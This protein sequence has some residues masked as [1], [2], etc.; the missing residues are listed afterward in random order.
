MDRRHLYRSIEQ[1]GTGD[2]DRK[3]N[4]ADLRDREAG[5]RMAWSNDAGD[6]VSNSSNGINSCCRQLRVGKRARARHRR[7]K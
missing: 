7:T 3:Q 4:I 2:P 1:R 6:R 5:H